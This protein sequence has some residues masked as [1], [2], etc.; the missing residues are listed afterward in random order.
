MISSRVGRCEPQ[1]VSSVS[2]WVLTA[3][4]QGGACHPQNGTRLM[5][6]SL[7]PGV[8][9]ALWSERWAE[10]PAP[11]A[12]HGASASPG[13]LAASLVRAHTCLLSVLIPVLGPGSGSG[14]HPGLP[15]QG[16]WPDPGGV[17]R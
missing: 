4:L 14:P 6:W 5:E 9:R 16:T 7:G 17:A 3:A 13:A 8:L 11:S 2:C 12:S 1:G 10:G 15:C